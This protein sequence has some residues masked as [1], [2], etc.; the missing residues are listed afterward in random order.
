M[1]QVT[2]YLDEDTEALMRKNAEAAGISQ[3]KWVA[4]AIRSK[5]SREWP[6]TVLALVGAWAD[7]PTVEQIRTKVGK[8]ARRQRL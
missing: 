6:E 4:S 7:F 3:S 1:G 5:A 8:D 2:V